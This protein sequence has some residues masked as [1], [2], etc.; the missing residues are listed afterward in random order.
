MDTGRSPR[1][2][3]F[4]NAKLRAGDEW[5][6]VQIRNVSEG[7]LLVRVSEPPAVGEPV[8]IRRRGCCITGLVVWCTRSRMGVKADHA[9]NLERLTA[10]SGIGQRESEVKHDIPHPSFWKR[11]SGRLR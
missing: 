7:G 8:E 5:L 10:D 1:R 3:A 6:D 11:L 4:I 2:V 9:I